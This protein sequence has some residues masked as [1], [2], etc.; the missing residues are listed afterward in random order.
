MV[1]D[2]S[3]SNT[4]LMTGGA[5]AETVASAEEPVSKENERDAARVPL[6][7]RRLR[8][9][10]R[11]ARSLN[12]PPPD[13]SFERSA[14]MATAVDPRSE[15]LERFLTS[16]PPRKELATRMAM[17]GA[18]DVLRGDREWR[19][20]TDGL[21]EGLSPDALAEILEEADRLAARL[22]AETP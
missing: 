22:K 2:T 17:R 7:V 3:G 19:R 16:L 12:P 5:A 9:S 11:G 1:S 15:E 6:F 21:K 20:R 13:T 4:A 18:F 14:A 10:Q 8:S